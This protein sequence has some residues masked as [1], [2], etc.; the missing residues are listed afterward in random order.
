M[1]HLLPAE[2][3]EV[4]GDRVAVVHRERRLAD[5]DAVRLA[6]LAVEILAEQAFHE[7]GFARRGLAEK[8]D[9]DFVEFAAVVAEFFEVVAD[10]LGCLVLK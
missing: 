1:H 9:L 10:G 4:G 2:V 6:F 8:D 3:P 5:A 7:R